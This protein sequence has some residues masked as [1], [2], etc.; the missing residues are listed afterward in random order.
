VAKANLAA[1]S[2]S[3]CHR[4]TPRSS[5]DS[6]GIK[7][8]DGGQRLD[9]PAGRLGIQAVDDQLLGQIQRLTLNLH[10]RGVHQRRYPGLGQRLEFAAA[11]PVGELA[12]A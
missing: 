12:A 10:L 4:F 2:S 11:L 8:L 3:G 5:N 1:A 7:L 9:E 6:G